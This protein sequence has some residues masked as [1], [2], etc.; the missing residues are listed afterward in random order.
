MEFVRDSLSASIFRQVDSWNGDP[1]V[2]V[3]GYSS[4]S[5]AEVA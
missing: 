4:F 1:F 2:P 3:K 5:A